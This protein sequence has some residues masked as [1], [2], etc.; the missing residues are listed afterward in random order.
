MAVPGASAERPHVPS[1]SALRRIDAGIV[2]HNEEA[3]VRDSLRS[4][5]DQTLPSNVAWGTFWV[6][7]SG[8]T[9]RTVEIVEEVR[10]TEPRV[11]LVNEPAR[12]GKSRAIV[13]VLERA[14]GEA[15]VLLNSDAVAEPGSVG[16]LLAASE[17]AEP[18]FGI[19]GRPVPNVVGR[20]AVDGMVSLLWTLHHEFHLEM[21]ADAGG[22]HL[23]DE[24]LLVSL[25]APPAL[26]QGIINDGSFLGAW[27][28]LHRGTRRYAPEARVRIEAPRSFRDHLRQRRR[29]RVGDHQVT[30]ILGVTPSTVTTLSLEQPARGWA[31]IRRGLR[32]GEHPVR[33]LVL[34]SAAEV[35]ATIAARWD[36]TVR[37][38]DHVLWERVQRPSVARSPAGPPPRAAVDRPVDR[39]LRSLLEVAGRYRTGILVD[40]LADLLPEE[41]PPGTTELR[42]WLAD[43]PDLVA[44]KDDRAYLVGSAPERLQERQARALRYLAAAEQLVGRDLAAVRPWIRC[45][46]VTGSTAYGEPEAGDDLDLFVVVRDGALWAFL[47]HA[48]LAIRGRYRP[49]SAAGRPAPCLN[50]VL[51]ESEAARVF[52]TPRG[53]LFAREALSVRV[54][55]GDEY[56]RSLLGRA[57]WLGEEIPRLYAKRAPAPPGPSAPAAPWPVRL[58]SAALYV[59]L[60]AY[61][62]AVGLRR[63]ARFRRRGTRGGEFRTRT[64][65]G[66]LAFASAQFDAL[67]RVLRGGAPTGPGPIGRDPSHSLNVAR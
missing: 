27:L 37:G 60:A 3:T 26:R 11:H 32:T 18:P 6:V 31:V 62:Q 67:A 56:Y 20:P 47:A 65:P 50:F 53:F 14:R 10:A 4:L 40:H 29:I 55:V 28:S 30:S 43:R 23:S 48:Y 42:G 33:D 41:A 51:T 49:Q 57:S 9:D 7:A 38:R 64:R 36:L 58:L 25:P 1:P 15:V 24:L 8:C 44:V 66:E 21:R 45:A 59:P 61:L 22:T 52:G 16:A 39:R 12:R 2:A 63:N 34:V 13:E 5:L 46:G 19:M 35:T 17:G 54:L